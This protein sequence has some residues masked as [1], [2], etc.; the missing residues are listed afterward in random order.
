MSKTNFTRKL[1]YHVRILKLHKVK[2]AKKVILAILSVS[3]FRACIFLIYCSWE[4]VYRVEKNVIRCYILY[5]LIS[6]AYP[7]VKSSVKR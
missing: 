6:P 4:T 3:S 2:D 5:H 1:A 7:N